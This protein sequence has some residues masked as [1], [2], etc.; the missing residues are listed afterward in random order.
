[1]IRICFKLQI[2]D[3]YLHA[4]GLIRICIREFLFVYA[5]KIAVFVFVFDLLYSNI[6]LGWCL[7]WYCY[8]YAYTL[9][10]KFETYLPTRQ[11]NLFSKIFFVHANARRTSHMSTNTNATTTKPARSKRVRSLYRSLEGGG[12]ALARM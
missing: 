6:F 1:M 12:R 2:F 5:R 10:I 11:L 7:M 8:M 3:S 9:P 4:G